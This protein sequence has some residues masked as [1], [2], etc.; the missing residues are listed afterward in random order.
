MDRQVPFL[1]QIVKAIVSKIAPDKIILFGSYARGDYGKNSD[2]YKVGN[3]GYWWSAMESGVTR[4]LNREMSHN[5]ENVGRN[6]SYRISL[7]SVRCVQ[8]KQGK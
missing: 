3:E 7:F 6:S 4:A 8:D 2:F 5:D 1:D